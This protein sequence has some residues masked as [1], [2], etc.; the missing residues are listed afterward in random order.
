MATGPPQTFPRSPCLGMAFAGAREVVF[1]LKRKVEYI[2]I[3]VPAVRGCCYMAPPAPRAWQPTTEQQADTLLD[4]LRPAPV[5]DH[6]TA[7]AA[8]HTLCA[9]VEELQRTGSGARP[10][11]QC[12]ARDAV[13]QDSIPR[14]GEADPAVV[15]MQLD[16]ALVV[17]DDSPVPES[18]GVEQERPT[19]ASVGSPSASGLANRPEAAGSEGRPIVAVTPSSDADEVHDGL[20]R[21]RELR[22]RVSAMSTLMIIEGSDADRQRATT[23]IRMVEKHAHCSELLVFINCWL[24]RPFCDRESSS[25]I[26]NADASA[27][28]KEL[29]R[30]S[31]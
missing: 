6:D 24:N 17:M 8:L 28:R 1:A 25:I 30:A 20:I 9:L 26:A 13:V 27:V 4:W 5:V 18:H 21:D 29:V 10:R 11:G 15:G 22:A 23:G 19:P 12:S 3:Q 16:A 31:K 2:V 7:Q 14:P